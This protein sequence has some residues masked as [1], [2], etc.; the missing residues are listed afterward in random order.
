M[1]ADATTTTPPRASERRALTTNLWRYIQ[2]SDRF[3]SDVDGRT[4]DRETVDGRTTMMFGAMIVCST[5]RAP[6]SSSSSTI[7]LS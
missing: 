3:A 7:I 6:S 5:P 2:I 4:S 1:D